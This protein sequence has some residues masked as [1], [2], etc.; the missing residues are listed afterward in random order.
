MEFVI[1]FVKC[2]SKKLVIVV[3]CVGVLCSVVGIWWIVVFMY[4]CICEGFVKGL[5]WMW[6]MVMFRVLLFYVLLSCLYVL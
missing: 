5:F 3:C 6:L 1:V 4:I 2:W